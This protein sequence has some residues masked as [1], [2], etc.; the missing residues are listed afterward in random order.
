MRVPDT[1][2]VVSAIFSVAEKAGTE[3]VTPGMV[4]AYLTSQFGLDMPLHTVSET[5]SAL[6]IITHTVQNN[7]YIIWNSENMSE[8]RQT[9]VGRF[10][11]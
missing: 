9:Y 8:L 6:G 7:R 1:T 3:K 11:K 4:T 5:M 2:L 10:T